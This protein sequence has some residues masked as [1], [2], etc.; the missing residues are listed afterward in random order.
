LI[1]LIVAA[2]VGPAEIACAIRMWSLNTRIE[3][4]RCHLDPTASK[5]WIFM[6]R[7]H[8]GLDGADFLYGEPYYTEAASQQRKSTANAWPQTTCRLPCDDNLT[9]AA[10][11]TLNY[12]QTG[13]WQT[14]SS[15]F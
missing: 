7:L 4:K 13:S 8:R 1:I 9:H 10:R 6:G 12:T 2:C 3:G 5:F 15:C 11:K 14:G